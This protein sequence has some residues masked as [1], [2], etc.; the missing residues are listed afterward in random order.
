MMY[1]KAGCRKNQQR[2]SSPNDILNA[3]DLYKHIVFFA[4][5]PALTYTVHVKKGKGGPY[6]IAERRVLE[7]IIVLGNQPAGDTS[8]KPGG[9]LP[10]FSA[11]LAVTL[12]TLK[13]AA[14]NFTTW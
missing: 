4:Q 6:S 1:G 5:H 14:T 12:A 11:R 2:F 3:Q 10:L 7:L 9:R 8:H 13:S